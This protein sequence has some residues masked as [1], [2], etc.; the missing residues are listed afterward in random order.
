VKKFDKEIKLQIAVSEHP[1]YQRRLVIK[2]YAVYEETTAFLHRFNIDAT[3]EYFK[4]KVDKIIKSK[5]H[6]IIVAQQK[7][8]PLSFVAKKKLSGMDIFVTRIIDGVTELV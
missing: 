5:N 2:Y 7:S 4:E 6:S 8:N 3:Y 1:H